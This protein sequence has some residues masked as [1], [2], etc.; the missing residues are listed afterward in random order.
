M[1]G[2]WSRVKP[3][4]DPWRVKEGPQANRRA[5]RR[6]QHGFGEILCVARS[7]RSSFATRLPT[8]GAREN[9]RDRV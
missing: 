3:K 1:T 6:A 8:Q 2:G 4:R 9:R 7:V 5:H